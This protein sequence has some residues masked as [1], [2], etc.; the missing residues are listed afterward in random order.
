MSSQSKSERV[1]QTKNTSFSPEVS[2]TET[3][4][5]SSHTPR[6]DI[7]D[8]KYTDHFKERLRESHRYIQPPHVHTIVAEGQFRFSTDDGWR[9][10]YKT[11]GVELILVV[12]CTPTQTV[13][14]TGYARIVDFDTADSSDK[15]ND[16]AL[17]TIYLC[18]N[19]SEN[20]SM[21]P[22]KAIEN[23]EFKQ[24]KKLFGHEIMIG[25]DDT[26]MTC[27]VCGKT[28]SSKSSFTD[29]NCHL[30]T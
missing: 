25:E 6:R 7:D 28:G 5:E 20:S 4:P 8:Y 24:P 11:S 19:L 1:E 13:I 27:E 14:I 16:A 21:S 30:H 29:T 17:E 10:V 2:N 12:D 23:T 15:W 18:Q 9:V 26:V 3:T 22:R